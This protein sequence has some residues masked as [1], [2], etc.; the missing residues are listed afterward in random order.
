AFA[1]GQGYVG[2]FNLIQGHNFAEDSWSLG[3]HVSYDVQQSS[4]AVFGFMIDVTGF[5]G[6]TTANSTGFTFAAGA[7]AANYNQRIEVD[8]NFLATARFRTGIA[9]GNLLP[10][11][12]A[13]ISLA[14]YEV[15]ILA[16]YTD[17]IP[18]NPISVF[19]QATLDKLAL[20]GVIGAGLSWRMPSGV[21]LTAEGLY[22][23]I[24]SS[25]SLTGSTP[26]S[27]ADQSVKLDDIVEARLKLS[28][29]LN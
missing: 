1:Q 3:G 16:T 14:H 28:M 18:L 11:F 17:T 5:F 8:T 15:D 26:N 24:G 10:Y 6:E 25:V 12:T 7:G 27:A 4:N 23:R 22:H 13:G 29:P 2:L 19:S 21:I 9:I 20:G